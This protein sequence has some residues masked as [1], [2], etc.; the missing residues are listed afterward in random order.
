MAKG[1]KLVFSLLLIFSLL[2]AACSSGTENKTNNDNNGNQGSQVNNNDQG[3]KEQPKEVKLHLVTMFGGTDPAREA[4]MDAIADFESANP[5]VT[6]TEESLTSSGNEFRTKVNADFQAGNDPD[7]TYFFTGKEVEPLIDAGKLVA[8]DPLFAEDSAWHDSFSEAA[9]SAVKAE[10]G[11]IYA[12]PLTGYYEGLF[13]NKRLFEENNVDLPTDWNKY[14]AAIE[15]FSKTDIIPIAAPLVQSHYLVEHYTLSAGGQEAHQLAFPDSWAKG[16]NQLGEDIK[17]GAFPKDAATIDLEMAASYFQQ[18]KAAMTIEGSWSVG[19]I[20]DEVKPNISVLP[21][22]VMPGGTAN[23]GDII[24]G[25]GS[26][27]YLSTKA[28]DDANK[29]DTAVKLLKYLTS[30]EVVTAISHANS[31]VPAVKGVP[32]PE[33]APQIIEDGF[34]LV[35][36]ATSGSPAIDSYISGESFTFIREHV[37]HIGD[38]EMTAEEVLAEAQKLD[39]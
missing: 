27:W 26:G 7:L 20:P 9:L 5:G 25:F 8:L 38:G 21:F 17:L 28:Y 33:G 29:K 24:A 16:L 30:K 14:Q 1:T 6:I 13:V 32:A 18:E 36:N 10:D 22:P 19:S 31:G 3:D 34:A 12:A 4:F 23:Y 11:K 39:N 37:G 15:A 2:L 35:A